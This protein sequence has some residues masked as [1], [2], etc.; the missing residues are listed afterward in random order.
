MNTIKNKSK[1]I[2]AA[3]KL[4]VVTFILVGLPSIRLSTGLAQTTGS[5]QKKERHSRPGEL[6]SD[7]KPM[8]QKGSGLPKMN[9]D[10]PLKSILINND[11]RKMEMQLKHSILSKK[12]Q[13]PGANVQPPAD[14]T[15]MSSPQKGRGKQV[16][17]DKGGQQSQ[18]GE[19]YLHIVLSVMKDGNTELINATEISG[20][21]IMSEEVLG[22]FV[23]EVAS[24]KE[25]LAVQSL[26]D[27]FERRSFSQP[28]VTP[29]QGHHFHRTRSASIIVKI[30]KMNLENKI[31]DKM[32]IK[33]YKIKPDKPIKKMNP[34][35]FMKLKNEKRLQMQG[36]ISGPKLSNQIKQKGRKAKQ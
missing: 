24:D 34:L 26:N 14:P 35:V 28:E 33:L 10:K 29:R 13:Y 27:P 4:M 36:K 25:I 23:Y 2:K 3:T 22:D 15:K 12:V 31:L 17:G 6:Q 18:P 20:K 30:P 1:I 21:A 8:H 32:S 5:N 19:S 9:P 7:P 16:P 11:I